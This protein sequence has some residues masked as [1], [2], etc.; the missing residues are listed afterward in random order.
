MGLFNFGMA[1]S[2][3]KKNF[4]FK[5]VKLCFKIDLVSHDEEFG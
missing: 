4:K 1:S 3:E 2:L 5:P